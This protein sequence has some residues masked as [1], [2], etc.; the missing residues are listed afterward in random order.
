MITRSI[1]DVKL[2]SEIAGE[3]IPNITGDK[4][5][6]DNSWLA[7][8]RALLPSRL[9]EGASAS[10]RLLHM[11]TPS[12]KSR[13]SRIEYYLNDVDTT[14]PY[15]ITVL[16]V[17]PST[18]DFAKV[19]DAFRFC[20]IPDHVFAEAIFNK[21]HNA[22]RP[23]NVMIYTNHETANTVVIVER[24]TYGIWHVLQGC[25][26]KVMF[27]KLF[28]AHP[29]TEDE[30]KLIQALGGSG[31]G[32]ATYIALMEK[33]AERYDLRAAE[34]RKAVAEMASRA[35]KCRITEMKNKIKEFDSTIESC[36]EAI[37]NAIA[38]RDQTRAALVGFELGEKE[39]TTAKTLTDFFLANQRVYMS[40]AFGDRLTYWVKTH[41]TYWDEREAASYIASRG[42]YLYYGMS[43]CDAPEEKWAQMLRDIF[44][45]RKVRVRMCA[46]YR[47]MI[48]RSSVGIDIQS[49]E[50]RPHELG[51][52]LKNPHSMYHNCWGSHLN[53]VVESLNSHDYVGA[54]SATIAATAQ[55]T[56]GDVSTKQ[57]SYW[58]GQSAEACIEL[59]DGTCMTCAEYIATL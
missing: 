28:E 5:R 42:S 48:G 34:I 24:L 8:M 20:G 47:L 12:K 41:L 40:K 43:E 33:F 23:I 37:F 54:I 25:M 7:T 31:D 9:P 58:L 46:A 13:A 19:I 15:T 18:E 51:S 2:A 57:F 39:D 56:I 1:G 44:V 45:D 30:E 29:C 59:P 36:R 27:K 53:N 16:N 4:Y 21:L 6:E 52:Y 49:E 55:L 3:L 32:T 38:E 50:E 14:S 17:V 22:E 35:R 10:L 11:E 26:R